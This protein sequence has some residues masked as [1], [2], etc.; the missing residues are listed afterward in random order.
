[1]NSFGTCDLAEFYCGFA[2]L[3]PYESREISSEPVFSFLCQKLIRVFGQYKI[4]MKIRKL[5][6]DLLQPL[7]DYLARYPIRNSYFIKNLFRD[8]NRSEF[9]LAQKNFKI[10]GCL[11][12]YNSGLRQSSV[13]SLIGEE[14]AVLYLLK[15]CDIKTNNFLVLPRLK[16]EVELVYSV[17][18]Y[19]SI[20]IMQ[21]NRGDEKVF[22]GNSEKLDLDHVEQ[23]AR[24]LSEWRGGAPRNYIEGIRERLEKESY[25]FFGKFDN[26]KLVSMSALTILPK[27]MAIISNSFT[28]PEYRGQGYVISCISKCLQIAFSEVKKAVLFVFTN[29]MKAKKVYTSIG[30]K[31]YD[32]FNWLSLGIRDN[33]NHSPNRVT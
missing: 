4:D 33:S 8:R 32:D 23:I 5:S 14:N 31:L 12:I 25:Y 28:L 16:K 1:M 7:D 22:S 26:N 3:S 17:K 24:L 29:N 19:K 11:L 2:L 30:F 20:D 6:D 9:Y 10:K 21:I 13:A 27:N 15:K 18:D